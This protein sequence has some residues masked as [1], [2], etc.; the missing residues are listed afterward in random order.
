[1]RELAGAARRGVGCGGTEEE[2]ITTAMVVE[3]VEGASE[4]ISEVMP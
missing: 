1:M 4:E 2:V 3:A